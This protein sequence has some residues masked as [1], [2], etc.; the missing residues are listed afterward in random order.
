MPHSR[1]SED[2][3]LAKIKEI[4]YDG[5]RFEAAAMKDKTYKQ[6][7]EYTLAY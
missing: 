5:R 7:V 4:F 6:H 2:A 1:W 3:Y